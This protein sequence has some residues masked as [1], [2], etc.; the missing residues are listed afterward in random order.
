MWRVTATPSTRSSSRRHARLGNTTADGSGSNRPIVFPNEALRR[1]RHR[2]RRC[3]F[4]TVDQLPSLECVAISP[5][6]VRG[7]AAPR[8]AT[9]LAVA[10]RRVSRDDTAS[11]GDGARC[12]SRRPRKQAIRRPL[13]A[14]I[15]RPGP[16]ARRVATPARR[17][18]NNRRLRQVRCSRCR[19][20]FLSSCPVT[21][22]STEFA[23]QKQSTGVLCEVLSLIHT[24]IAAER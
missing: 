18:R 1:Q 7:V 20:A 6:G 22:F 21:D 4:C 12:A 11:S 14:L 15:H 24:A 17:R 13:Q 9:P 23:S 5:L 8:R 3:G 10:I 2:I 19:I 16:P